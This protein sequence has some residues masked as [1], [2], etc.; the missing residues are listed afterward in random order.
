MQTPTKRPARASKLATAPFSATAAKLIEQLQAEAYAR[1][2]VDLSAKD[3]VVVLHPIDTASKCIY[4]YS[5]SLTI[6]DEKG[7]S[8]WMQRRRILPESWANSPSLRARWHPAYWTGVHVLV[9]INGHEWQRNLKEHVCDDFGN[10]VQVP[11]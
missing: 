3:A 10:L 2:L 4:F 11:T 9:D 8:V 6:E 5:D 1:L 7:N